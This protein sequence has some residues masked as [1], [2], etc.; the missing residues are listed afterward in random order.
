M[1]LASND[2]S[3]REQIALLFFNT[4]V[5]FMDTKVLSTNCLLSHSKVCKTYCKSGTMTAFIS[6]L[7]AA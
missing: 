7:I 2:I 1:L 6:I 3:K 4:S 5:M